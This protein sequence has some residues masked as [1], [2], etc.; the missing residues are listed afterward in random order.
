MNY[1]IPEGF[2]FYEELNKTIE[3]SK[4]S[5]PERNIHEENKCL[6]SGSD[7]SENAITLECGHSFNYIPLFND[8]VCYKYPKQQGHYIYSDNL[9]LKDH[10]LRCPYC[11]QVQENLL[12]YLPDVEIKKIKG[13]NYPMSLCMGKNTCSHIFKSGKNKGRICG[14]RCFREKCNQHFKPAIN[15]E[16]FQTTK[17]ALS[18]LNLVD[19]R[20][21]AKLKG[22]KKYSKLKKNDLIKM[23]VSM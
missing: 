20:K 22:A 14:K 15:L 11:R 17:E 4:I 23:L 3:A 5:S 1:I 2:D 13:V 19:L 21:L 6:I 16:S 7:L 9:Y 12:P 8:L 18:K 10:E